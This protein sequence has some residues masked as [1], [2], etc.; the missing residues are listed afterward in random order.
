M[1]YFSETGQQ[2]SG[3]NELSFLPTKRPR[4]ASSATQ[5]SSIRRKLHGLCATTRVQAQRGGRALERR[6][7]NDCLADALGVAFRY[8]CGLRRAG[9]LALMKMATGSAAAS[10]MAVP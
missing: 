6:S 9:V 10:R 1:G 3:A 8:R 4:W 5:L 2:V 7:G